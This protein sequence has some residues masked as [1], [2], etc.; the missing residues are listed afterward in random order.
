MQTRH[1]TCYFIGMSQRDTS[2]LKNTGDGF[3]VTQFISEANSGLNSRPDFSGGG[4]DSPTRLRACIEIVLIS[5]SIKG[6][7]LGVQVCR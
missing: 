2:I 4:S 7:P 6:G 5:K 3:V 1:N